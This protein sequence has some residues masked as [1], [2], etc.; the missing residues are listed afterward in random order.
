MFQMKLLIILAW[1]LCVIHYSSC[2]QRLATPNRQGEY[3]SSYRKPV[4]YAWSFATIAANLSN[5]VYRRSPDEQTIVSPGGL[6]VRP[7]RPTAQHRGWKFGACLSKTN[8]ATSAHRNAASREERQPFKNDCRFI[9]PR[10]IGRKRLLGFSP[11]RGFCAAVWQE[12]RIPAVPSR[13]ARAP[14]RR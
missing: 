4:L 3:H 5:R 14:A 10:P 1:L 13:S 11:T 9:L 6:F 7:E 2:R 12:D 8:A